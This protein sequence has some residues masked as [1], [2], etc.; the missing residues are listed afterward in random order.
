[1][2]AI[3]IYKFKGRIYKSILFA[4]SSFAPRLTSLAILILASHSLS[5]ETF[6]QYVLITTLGELVNLAC[7]SWIRFSL[8]RLDTSTERTRGAGYVLSL[9]LM[10]FALVPALAIAAITSAIFD[11]PTFLKIFIG[12]C[13]YSVGTELL[14][15]TLTLIQISD[16]SII[17]ASIEVS[18]CV[19][20]MA[21]AF[22][23][24]SSGADFFILSISVNMITLGMAVF[25]TAASLRATKDSFEAGASVR[26]RLNYGFPIIG[27]MVLQYAFSGADRLVIQTFAGAAALGAYAATA[28]ISQQIIALVSGSISQAYLPD[29]VRKYEKSPPKEARAFLIQYSA[30]IL[31][32]TVTASVVVILALPF[33]VRL[34]LPEEFWV[35]AN[36]VGP[37]LVAVAATQAIKSA[38]VDNIFHLTKKNNIQ[39]SILIPVS[40]VTIVFYIV[41]IPPLGP[42]GAALAVLIGTTISIVLGFFVTR[43]FLP[44]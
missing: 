44:R 42:T 38:I 10:I 5:P 24:T 2:R 4:I 3:D 39:I 16:K 35:T 32:A 37:I 14:R 36:E 18:R 12:I 28:S 17:Y 11:A 15:L 26:D 41:L 21:L 29:L 13:V 7:F 43:R 40:I 30:V 27:L 23:L 20:Q 25:I 33:L 1:M 9:K 31:I 8:W 6:G 34:M 22:L 19:L